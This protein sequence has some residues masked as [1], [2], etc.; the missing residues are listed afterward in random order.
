MKLFLKTSLALTLVTGIAIM[1]HAQTPNPSQ[2]SD[3]SKATAAKSRSATTTDGK[4]ELATFGGGC[5]WCIEAVF[6][7]VNG[8][9]DV[10]SG[11]SGDARPR[12][13]NPSYEL[14]S[15]HR[16]QHAEVC[17][18]KY[19]PKVISYKELLEIFWKVHD[20]TTKDA[21]GP[22]HGPQYRSVIFTHSDEQQQLA[23]KYKKALN[24]EKAY[25]NR[26]VLTE[27]EPIG[28]FYLAEEYHQDF[29]RKNPTNAYCRIHAQPKID[30][31]RAAFRD[32][33]K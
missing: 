17:Q 22:D 18:I 7:N 23:E 3:A 16:T 27:I 20:P 5:F 31:F 29:Y 4:Y 1:I 12:Y 26:K 33:A 19:D 15:S 25:G 21:Q 2:P 32:K 8:V 9:E 24:D 11:Y 14:V 6:E 30:K 13:A 10:V 28:E